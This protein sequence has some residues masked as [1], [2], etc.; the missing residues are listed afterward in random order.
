M[1]S[2]IIQ[3]MAE[4]APGNS[5]EPAMATQLRD[6]R[7]MTL[8]LADARDFSAFFVKQVSI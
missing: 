3:S 8:L 5:S 7:Q 2:E 1:P 4:S 6:T